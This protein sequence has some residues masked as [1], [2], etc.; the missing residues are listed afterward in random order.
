MHRKGANG[1][2]KK[3]SQSWLKHADFVILD[4]LI[5]VGAFFLAFRI[6]HG[7][8]GRHLFEMYKTG[9]FVIALSNLLG[10]LIFENHKNI[11]RRGYGQEFIA[12]VKM[13]L[14]D[15][16][17][18]L[19]YFFFWK[20][21]NRFSR[22]IMVY[23]SII[24]II[25]MY[26]ERVVWKKIVIYILNTRPY[27]KRHMLLV[28]TQTAA[29]TVIEKVRNNSYGLIEIIGLV[30][31][32]KDV[33]VG[34]RI[35]DVPV[36]ATMDTVADYMQTLWIDEVM[37]YLPK[38][39]TAIPGN[40]IHVCEMM[41]ITTHINLDCISDTD[42]MR[43]IDKV[44]GIQVLTESIRFAS[45]KQV[46]AKR[47]LDILG[48]I[49]GLFFTG[50]LTI[51]V[52][53]M[54]YFSDPGPIFF[55]QM[56]VGMNGRKFRI[57]KFRSMYQD[58][59]ARKK[60]LMQKNE[61]QGLMFKMEADPRIIGSGPDGTKR[62]IG[63]FI[64]TTSIDEFPQFWNV[65]KGEMSLVGTRPPT[66][67]EWEQYEAHHRA[68]LSIRPGLTGLWQVSGR[69]DITDFEEVIALDMKYINNW[70]IYEDIR[71]IFMTVG[72][73]FSGGGAK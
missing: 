4:I 46:F 59:E 42:C 38:G 40:L 30:I 17:G 22:S 72:I 10:A 3:K 21:G 53:P 47:M 33:P 6:R 26:V 24:A 1:L 9:A 11:L 70:T 66:E 31:D 52:G 20:I 16:V 5:V 35:D 73:I 8:T 25:A 48:A 19:F 55:S 13:I 63:W 67:D 50:I 14:I 37:I 68:R 12:V 28:S 44:G 32:G 64:R 57:Y 65:L 39:T 2:Y 43:T 56:R 34:T 54:I 36:V 29:E 49:V 41:G 69:S 23:F 7:L 62:G 71:I 61:M 15:M 60:E 18:M 45:E 51:I 58:A 27:Q